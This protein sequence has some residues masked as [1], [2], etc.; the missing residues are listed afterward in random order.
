MNGAP[1]SAASIVE[2]APGVSAL[3]SGLLWLH[4]TRTIVAAD[5]HF[6]YED[7]IGGALPMWSTPEITATLLAA[8]RR[9]KAEEIVLLGDVIHGSRMSDGAACAVRE[10]LDGLR[11]A[12]QLTLVAGNHE[13][14]SRGASILGETVEFA[15]RDGW[16]L[17]HG[18]KSV[19]G[20]RCIIGHLH[21]SLGLGGGMSAPAFLA[22]PRLVVVPAMTP[23]SRGLDVFSNACMHALAPFGIESRRELQVVVAAGDLLYPFGALSQIRTLM[24]DYSARRRSSM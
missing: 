19:G 8:A 1:R 22:S 4:A 16:L 13:G 20:E 17:L 5:V 3:A 10:S 9:M 24:R 23:Y 7:V 14:R 21:P 11:A 18:D 6:A 15:R 12:A 2:L